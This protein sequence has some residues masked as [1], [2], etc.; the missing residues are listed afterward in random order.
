MDNSRRSEIFRKVGRDSWLALGIIG[1]LIV[2]FYALGAIRSVVVPLLIAF[3]IGTLLQPLVAALE[4]RGM[5]PAFAAS[6]ALLVSL[7]LAGGLIAML[8][9]GFID[10]MPE[11]YQ[12]L[13]D[14]WRSLVVWAESL[15]LDPLLLERVREQIGQ[16]GAAL[17]SG[18]LGFAPSALTSI[19][20]FA[21]GTF[22]ALFFLF[23]VLRDFRAFPR[24]IAKL[25][26]WNPRI[27]ERIADVASRSLRGYFRGTAVTAL[28]TGPIFL[29]PLIFLKVPL[30]IPIAIL[31]FFLSFIPFVGAWITAV[32]AL[33]IVFGSG[34]A[35]AALIAGVF[36]LISNGAIQNAV[37]SW[38]LGASLRLH[39]VSVL[40]STMVG[41]AVAGILGM[42]LGAPLLAA[43]IKSAEVLREARA[44]EAGRDRAHG[45]AGEDAQPDS[46]PA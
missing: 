17:G 22:F 35:V 13:M 42:V 21:L 37:A 40:I 32:F 5:K 3:I 12:Q 45:E 38:A 34:G 36:L 16:Y 6:V 39:P 14:G 27:A 44:E 46:A 1:L 23:F 31:Y 19:L 10:Q 4:K 41:G 9:L 25:G 33:L 18:L 15:D 30:I 26:N 2:G 7:I 11:I 29:I 20:A 24:W 28:I 8:V 43:A